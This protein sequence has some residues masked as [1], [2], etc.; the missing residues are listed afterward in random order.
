MGKT[1]K[2]RALRMWYGEQS[3]LSREGGSGV[4]WWSM[5]KGAEVGPF[6]VLGVK[7]RAG[8][9]GQEAVQWELMQR[10]LCSQQGSFCCPQNPQGDF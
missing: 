6:R 5:Y 7:G 8:Q 9:A 4:E 10:V 1:W 3:H 2:G